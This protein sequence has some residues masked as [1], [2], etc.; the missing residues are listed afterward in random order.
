MLAFVDWLL[1]CNI[2]DYDANNYI[3]KCKL[4]N[5]NRGKMERMWYY[6][7]PYYKYYVQEKTWRVYF[8]KGISAM[9]KHSNMDFYDDTILW[10]VKLSLRDYQQN[11]I[12]NLSESNLI[13]APTGSWKSFII[14]WM[15]NKWK[16]KK[17]L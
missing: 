5:K 3:R 12:D 2:A 11:I 17:Y 14:S 16:C 7:Q 6:A 10:E 4:E 15:I 1:Y 9:A 8:P 13:V